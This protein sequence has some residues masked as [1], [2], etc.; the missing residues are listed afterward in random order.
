MTFSPTSII[1]LSAK[2]EPALLT[3]TTSTYD[4]V[5]DD[6][7]SGA[8]SDVTI[9]RPKAPDGWFILGD[10]A[11]G[12][13]GAPFGSALLVKATNDDPNNPLIKP[14]TSYSQVWTDRSSGGEYDGS[15]WFPVPPEGYLSV[16]F[17]GQLGWSAPSIVTYA[18]L[19]RDL[20]ER[21][22]AGQL[23]WSDQ[24]SGAK[25]DVALFQIVGVANAFVAQA[26]YAPYAG[27]A[28]K[29]KGT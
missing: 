16:G 8:S 13:Y 11:Q 4:W 15:I 19:R 20:V 1:R 12:N 17:V 27:S 6:S 24:E 26:N 2:G 10:Y 14:P 22:D 9:W 23:I 5:Y 21:A 18:C 29:L 7:G 25:D 3:S 28:Y